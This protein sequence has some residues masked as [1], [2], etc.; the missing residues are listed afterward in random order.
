VAESGDLIIALGCLLLSAE[1]NIQFSAF[2]LV[3]LFV[4]A[5][6]ISSNPADRTT[7]EQRLFGPETMKLDTFTKIREWT[8][9]GTPDGV[10]AL[11][12]F[13][14]QFGDRGKAAGTV[15]FEFYQYRQGWADP[16]GARIGGPKSI[17]LMTVD[18]QKAHWDR[19]SGAYSFQ[20]AYDGLR[21][22]RNYVLDATFES[23]SGRRFFSQLVLQ[24][25]KQAEPTT[26]PNDFHP[27]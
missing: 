7:A 16:R 13:D 23:A 9:R 21:S 6:C 27:L 17:S 1:M 4:L 11:L 5:G 10:E 20:L 24:P 25:E 19:A 2:S 14:D 12:E 18:D 15:L 8:G 22:D 26:L 3:P